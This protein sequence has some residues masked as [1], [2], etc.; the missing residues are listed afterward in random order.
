MLEPGMEAMILCD[1]LIDNG[2]ATEDEIRLVTSINGFTVDT[3]N[4]ILYSRV[5]YRDWKQYMESLNREEE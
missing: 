4:Q 3:L 1:D 5:G 2:I